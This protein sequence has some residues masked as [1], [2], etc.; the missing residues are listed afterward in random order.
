MEKVEI[1][2]IDTETFQAAFASLDRS[3]RAGV[4][5]IDLADEE[6]LVAQIRNCLPNDLFRSPV[7][8]HFRRIDNRHA[9]LDRFADACHLLS[10]FGVALAHVPG[11][12]AESGNVSSRG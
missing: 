12:D 11:A 4:E 6:H 7:G 5:G 10:L 2:V 8:I 9:E 1:Q 3:R